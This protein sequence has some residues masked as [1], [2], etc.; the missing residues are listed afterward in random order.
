[1]YFAQAA[2]AYGVLRL[3]F[4]A[5]FGRRFYR[6]AVDRGGGGGT[7]HIHIRVINVNTLQ[8]SAYKSVYMNI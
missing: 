8:T 6:D 5:Q 4:L 1:M 3:F 2:Y 7:L